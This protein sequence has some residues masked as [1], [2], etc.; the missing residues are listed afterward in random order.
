MLFSFLFLLLPSK[1]TRYQRIS[2]FSFGVH[3]GDSHEASFQADM[4][5]LRFE[6]PNYAQIQIVC[7]WSLCYDWGKSNDF[8]VYARFEYVNCFWN[9]SFWLHT[10]NLFLDAIKIVFYFQTIWLFISLNLFF[11]H[12]V[13]CAMQYIYD[14]IIVYMKCYRDIQ[15]ALIN[16]H[17]NGFPACSLIPRILR[18][19]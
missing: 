17:F 7:V 4:C 12:R 11:F 1:L 6:W 10:S 2:E 16:W 13:Y 3:C 8:H 5:I 14:W 19:V 18:I 15:F 9:A